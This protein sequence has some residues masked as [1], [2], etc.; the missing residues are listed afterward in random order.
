[1]MQVS[2][3]PQRRPGA[4]R[5]PATNKTTGYSPPRSEEHVIIVKVMSC[6]AGVLTRDSCPSSISNPRVRTPA[7]QFVC[8]GMH[9]FMRSAHRANHPGAQRATPPESGGEFP[10]PGLS[11]WIL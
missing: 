6:S 10:R 11:N 4:N 2:E 7:L 5:W 3:I 9:G 8:F 1:M